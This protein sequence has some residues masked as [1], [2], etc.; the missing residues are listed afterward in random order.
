MVLLFTG[1]LYTNLN[2]FYTPGS[3]PRLIARL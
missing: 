3:H 2:I 1:G